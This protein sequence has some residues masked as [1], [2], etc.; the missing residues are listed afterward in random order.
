MSNQLTSLYRL[1]KKEVKIA[2]NV[3]TR[4]F[5]EDKLY[6]YLVP[7]E[8]L[9]KTIIPLYYACVIRNGIQFGEVYTTSSKIEGLAIWFE[10]IKFKTNIWRIIRAGGLKP[11]FK[12]NKV[13][14]KRMKFINKYT[15][16]M[17]KQ[18]AAEKY[19]YLT[20]IGVDPLYQGK[21]FGSK[22]IRPMLKYIDSFKL[23]ILLETH[24][25]VNVKIYQKYGFEILNSTI[26][27][28]TNISHWL[29]ERPPMN[30]TNL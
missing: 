4:A 26:I 1:Q 13:I 15:Y 18:Y 2:A 14:I 23:P 11:L 29:M 10:S 6:Q 22:L 24:N 25:E 28:N 30:D 8:K 16:E 7:N 3:I 27:P 9:R 20:L 5:N 19:W 17:H 12:A 21:G